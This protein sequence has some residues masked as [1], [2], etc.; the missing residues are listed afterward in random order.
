M[1]NFNSVAIYNRA[2]EI[3]SQDPNWRPVLNNSVVSS[4]MKSNAETLAETARYAEYLFKESRWDA[5]QNTS[6]FLAMANMLGYQPKRKISARGSIYVSVDPRITQVGKTIS[7]YDFEEL[8]K[9]T[10]STGAENR[11][12]NLVFYTPS[13]NI[14][15]NSDWIIKDTRGVQYITSTVEFDKERYAISL[16]ILQGIKKQIFI[17]ISTIRKIATSSKLDPYIYIPVEIEDCENASNTMSK[18]YFKVATMSDRTHVLQYWRVVNTLLLSDATDFDVEVYNDMYSQKLFY[19]KFNNDPSR[20]ATL[21]LTENSSIAF[22]RI[23][24]LES[25]GEDG[26]L[27]DLFENF[28]LTSPYSSDPKLYGINYLAINAGANEETISSIKRN[29]PK[30]YISNYTAGTKEA[31]ENTILNLDL[32]VN[33]VVLR[34]T[35]VRVYGS[36]TIDTNGNT[37]PLTCISFIAKGLEDLV[38]SS[39]VLNPYT[40][41]EDSLNFYL[42]RLKSPQD[43]LKF[44]APNY[45]PFALGLKC[46]I[47]KSEAENLVDLLDGIRQI[48][49]DSWGPNSDELDF[50]RNFYQT[51]I[52]TAITNK[53]P[54]VKNVSIELEALARLNWSAAKRISPYPSE[55]SDTNINEVQHT[56]RTPFSFNNIFLGS[57]TNKGFKDYRTGN[58]Y[59]MRIDFYYKK[60]K[61]LA[62]ATNNHISLF[63]KEDKTRTVSPFYVIQDTR[64][65]W[66]YLKDTIA[67]AA[68]GTQVEIAS[69]Y[70]AFSYMP[71]KLEN[72][73]QYYLREQVYTDN[74]FDELTD[75][76]SS[77][78]VASLKTEENALGTLSDYLIYFSANY[79]NT[80]NS[81]ASGWIEL[82]FESLY[83]LLWYYAV[84]DVDLRNKLLE[85]APL[86]LLQ[87]GTSSSS[88]FEAFISIL[89]EYVEAY[90][91][92]RPISQVLEINTSNVSLDNGSS[93]LY[94]DSY[95]GA[96]A[97]RNKNNLT[98][99][100]KTRMISID[101][102]WAED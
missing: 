91:C 80:S 14:N 3:L 50:E 49:E 97:S 73:Y 28:T 13:D 6:S 58:N 19:L 52:I 29:A 71:A 31:Y 7:S 47:A 4:V 23:D 68:P 39:D 89:N 79:D 72:S 78:Y 90:V 65:Y 55:G 98:S 101:Y 41:I 62:V 93:V 92:M 42:A 12:T 76:K 83:N 81:I 85:K 15:I 32:A 26:N 82:P 96:S 99:I 10:R 30:F 8:A 44:V 18:K 21:D 33:D 37:I 5:A 20:G 61:A 35:K 45:V 22:I 53:Y 66:Q 36:S 43:T 63:V 60:P 34:P 64:N 67:G 24:Y 86:S 88:Q 56:F 11:K 59:V 77:N 51:P 46:N 38:T 54:E 9:Y 74:D 25:L 102:R 84:A 57:E 70:D 40:S 87:C 94:I 17:P 75:S 95:D 100:K 16:E 2:A 69:T 1:I 27:Y 48:I